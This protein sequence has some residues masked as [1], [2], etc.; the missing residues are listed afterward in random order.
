MCIG[1]GERGGP[2]RC[3]GDALKRCERARSAAVEAHAEVARLAQQVAILDDDAAVFE[4]IRLALDGDLP[5]DREAE[6]LQR[7]DHLIAAQ[8]HPRPDDYLTDDWSR[9]IHDW[10][11][12]V[13]SDENEWQRMCTEHDTKSLPAPA[14]PRDLRDEYRQLCTATGETPTDEGYDRYATVEAHAEAS[15]REYVTDVISGEYLSTYRRDL[16]E[17]HRDRASTLTESEA[18][19]EIN[20]RITDARFTQLIEARDDTLHHQQ[21]MQQ[22]WDEA[23]ASGDPEATAAAHISLHH[24]N[25]DYLVAADNLSDYK[26]GTAQYA[27]RV[28]ELH[29]FPPYVDQALG[30]CH[31]IGE[32]EPGSREWLEARQRGIGGSDV[33]PILGLG[34]YKSVSDVKQ[35]KLHPITD[36]Q[37][38]E[39]LRDLAEHTGPTARGHAWEPVL[40]KQYAAENPDVSVQRTKATWQSNDT[41][42]Q[43]INIDAAIVR[44]GQLEGIWEGKT[45]NNAND[46]KDGIP[47][48]YRPQLGQMMDATGAKYAD[49]TVNI[50]DIDVRTFRMHRND[51]LDPADPK[52]RTYA[53]RKHEVAKAWSSWQTEKAQ[54]KNPRTNSGTFA[55]VKKPGS[56]SSHDKNASTAKQLA[57]WRGISQHQAATLIAD[58]IATGDA[59]DAAIRSLYRSYNPASDPHRKYVVVDMETNGLHAGKHQVIQSAYE[60]IDGSGSTLHSSKSNHDITARTARTTGTGATSVHGLTYQDVHN[61]PAFSASEQKRHLAKYADDPNVTFVAHN[62]RFEE[63][64][65]RA[66]GIAPERVIDTMVLSQKFDH[67]STGAKLSDFTAAHGVDYQNA[68]DAG[69]DV[70]MTAAA[71]INFWKGK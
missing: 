6:L 7:A 41:D 26:D 34:A 53:D 67:T 19:A 18:E 5:S 13:R 9:R 62:A 37:V 50:D 20:N 35:S 59:P 68:H 15:H 3:S 44:D 8:S 66:Q 55:W 43:R 47:T 57:G 49:I 70:R 71:L 42:F 24:A 28:G 23:V 58:R 39:Q 63:R 29:N 31:K 69:N 30:D 48:Y 36:E 12:T 25:A 10:E 54:P 22:R 11:S 2:K 17:A 61:T 21:A 64:F 40:A 65:L 32:F 1:E 52:R 60:V 45:A 56:Q 46:W 4:N 38:T 27:A 16:I 51:P 14:A 33:A